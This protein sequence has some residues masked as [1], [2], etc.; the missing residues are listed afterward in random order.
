MNLNRLVW[1]I[2]NNL[3]LLLGDPLLYFRVL[4]C[5]TTHNSI[6]FSDPYDN[7]LCCV[8]LSVNYWCCF[9]ARAT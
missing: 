9:Q 4:K 1:Q 8:A 6:S 7:H 3:L 5:V 2:V